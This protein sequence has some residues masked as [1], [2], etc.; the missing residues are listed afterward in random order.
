MQRTHQSDRHGF[1]LV[2]LCIVVAVIAVLCAIALPKLKSARLVAN[3]TSAIATLRALSTAQVQLMA[4]GSIDTDGDGAGE[5]GYFAEMAGTAGMRTS[6]GGLPAVGPDHLHPS[7]L[8][9][10]LG[11]VNSAGLVSHSGYFFQIWLPGASAGGLTPG[12]S[13]RPT[14][15]G[16]DPA[17]LPDSDGAELV[18]CAYAWPV[19][20]T[21]TGNR[22]FFIN[23]HGDILQC[24]NR[25]PLPY[26]NTVKTPAFD[27]AYSVSGDMGSLPRVGIPG[28]TDGTVWQPVQ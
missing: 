28:G 27:E 21:E 7:V 10:A 25:V 20:T 16:A 23:Q 12:I 2:E 4:Q 3:E 11:M 5:E 14:V 17:D 9:T 13:E 8:A 18:W 15:G 1:T 24:Q 19:A 26:T 22:A 6:V